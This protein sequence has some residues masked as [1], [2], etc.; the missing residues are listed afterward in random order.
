MSTAKETNPA[1]FR[2]GD[3]I[4]R[5]TVWTDKLGEEGVAVYPIAIVQSFGKKQGTAQV[6]GENTRHRLYA[7]DPGLFHASDEEAAIA[8][9]RE[10]L[11]YSIEHSLHA[12]SRNVETEDD[13]RGF[14]KNELA[15][16]QSQADAKVWETCKV[17]RPSYWI[18]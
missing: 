15:E 14:W 7:G 1:T 10:R 8:H 18:S 13:P 4:I 5:V 6:E 9:G 12:C 11:R 3:Q 2:K 16:R 17:V